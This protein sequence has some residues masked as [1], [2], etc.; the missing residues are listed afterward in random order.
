MPSNMLGLLELLLVLGLALGW[1]LV[2]LARLRR[3]KNR[4][5]KS[6][7]QMSGPPG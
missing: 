5:S 2:E 3:D 4:K 7:S 6:P 1:A